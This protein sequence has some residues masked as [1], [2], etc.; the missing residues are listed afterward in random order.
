VQ[1]IVCKI[2]LCLQ[3]TRCYLILHLRDTCYC[4]LKWPRLYHAHAVQELLLAYCYTLL[5]YCYQPCAYVVCYFRDVYPFITY[6]CYASAV[7]AMVLCP[8]VRPSV[9]LS[10]RLSVTSRSSTETAKRRITQRT[11]HDTPRSL[12]FWCQRSPR[13]ST[14]VTPNE[15]AECRWDSQ[16][17]RLSTNNRLYLENGTR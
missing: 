6:L 12:D 15:G 10:V 5:R 13:N 11:S 7:L 16:N 17:W 3:V 1:D 9:R 4:L 2:Y 14:G 8:S